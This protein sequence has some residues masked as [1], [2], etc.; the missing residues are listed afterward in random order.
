M[1][2]KINALPN[3]TPVTSP[4]DQ[5]GNLSNPTDNPT[6]SKDQTVGFFQVNFDKQ[7]QNISNAEAKNFVE[8]RHEARPAS[9]RRLPTVAVYRVRWPG[10][11][12]T[13]PSAARVWACCSP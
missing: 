12:T 7:T 5:S 9:R 1:V 11:P 8:Y 13:N 4:F 2:D 3:V 6:I 10:R